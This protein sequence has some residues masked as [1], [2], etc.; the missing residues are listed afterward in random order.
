MC[1]FAV[2]TSGFHIA[3]RIIGGEK[4]QIE[5]FKWQAVLLYE[6]KL[7][8]GGAIISPTKIVSAAHCGHRITDIT[9]FQVRVGAVEFNKGGK[10]VNINRI[11]RHPDYNK[12]T[13]MNNDV[14]V[15]ML[16]E[17]LVFGPTIGPVLLAGGQ[18]NLPGGTM[19]H[20]SGYGATS[21]GINDAGA[22]RYVSVPIVVPAQC[23]KA[24]KKYHGIAKLT[25]KMIC[26]G[27]YGIGG[28]DSCVSRDSIRIF[29]S[30]LD[31][32]M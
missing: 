20:I 25:D 8:C 9:L 2:A 18:L 10:L 29:P 31:N 28:K 5:Q 13:S 12:P 17:A 15:I 16:R 32:S 7:Y 11:V 26:A 6:L 3:P 30:Q 23:K 19:V 14:A 27:F 22:L 1:K 21:P 24:Y 4:A